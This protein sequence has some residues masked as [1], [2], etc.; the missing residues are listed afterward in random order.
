MAKSPRPGV[1][2][3]E[4]ARMVAQSTM[5]IT[6]GD[7]P[8]VSFTP[9]NM[10]FK[11][12]AALRRVTGGLPFDAYWNDNI[13]LNEHSLKLA[14]YAARL[15]SGER[16]SFE[17]VEKEFPNPLLADDYDVEWSVPDLDEF[18]ADPAEA[19]PEE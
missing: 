11:V 13:Q 5:T 19:D 9:K 15:A 1:G 6:I 4:A 16:V 3:R 17:Q 14:W 18:L 8:P 10:S 7:H 2:K 12:D